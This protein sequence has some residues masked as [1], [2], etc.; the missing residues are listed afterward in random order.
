MQKH[1]IEKKHPRTALGKDDKGFQY[2]VIVDGR[3]SFSKGLSLPSLAHFMLT[4]LHCKQTLNIG[5]GGC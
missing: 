4:Q 2:I 3:S 5:G 1:L